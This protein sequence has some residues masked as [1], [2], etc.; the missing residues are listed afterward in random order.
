MI[1]YNFKSNIIVASC[2]MFIAACGES[3]EPILEETAEV[4]VQTARN[5]TVSFSETPSSST[6]LA[7]AKILIFSSRCKFLRVFIG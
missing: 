7:Y 2:L 5:L 3:S 4:T 6:E 1:K